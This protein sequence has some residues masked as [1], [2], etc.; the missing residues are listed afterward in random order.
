MGVWFKNTK[1]WY[2][3]ISK[4]DCSIYKKI[5]DWFWVI[6]RRNTVELDEFV[7]YHLE[8]RYEKKVC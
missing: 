4:K 2:K 6:F 5:A 8:H 1:R 3:L 7:L